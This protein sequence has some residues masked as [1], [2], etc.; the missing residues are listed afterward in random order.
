MSV[1]IRASGATLE[2][3][4]PNVLFEPHPLPSLYDA[5]ADGQRF[6]MISSG[7]EQSPPI[8]LAQNWEAGLKK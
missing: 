1:E 3:G 2:P 6:L 8:T 7:V 5:A 4:A